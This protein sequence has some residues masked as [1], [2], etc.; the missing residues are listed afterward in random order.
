MRLNIN[1]ATR[2]YRDV[3]RFLRTWGTGTALLAL[4]TI[5]LCWYTFNAWHQTRN[6][7]AQVSEVQ[8]EIDKLDRQRETGIAL[9]NQPQ[10]RDVA[11]QSA[12]LNGLIARRS[13]SWTL[14]FMELER[15]MP[16]RLHVTSIAPSL[17]KRNQIEIH[18]VVAGDAREQAVELVRRLEDSPAFRQPELRSETVAQNPPGTPNSPGG[19]RV[20][21]DIS[22]L[23]VPKTKG[24]EQTAE[25]EKAINPSTG[26]KDDAKALNPPIDKG[27]KGDDKA[28]G[29]SIGQKG[30]PAQAVPANA[31]NASAAAGGKGVAR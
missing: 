11:N 5:G 30:R 12:F 10:N 26:K 31:A 13:F 15:I 22:M 24:P 6:A 28:Q 29:T 2:P 18:M 27:K 23:Y 25:N 21:F 9:L 17:N 3:R 8:S 7:R 19:D 20:Q 1:L 16:A 4:L 14:L